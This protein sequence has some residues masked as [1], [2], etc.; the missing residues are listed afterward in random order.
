M[1]QALNDIGNEPLKKSEELSHQESPSNLNEPTQII[2]EEEKK[3]TIPL[4]NEPPQTN[5]QISAQSY[6]NATN[7]QSLKQP[8][9]KNE[10]RSVVLPQ[11]AKEN[12][13]TNNVKMVETKNEEDLKF[14]GEHEEY[15]LLKKQENSR[16]FQEAWENEKKD[17]YNIILWDSENW[18]HLV[19]CKDLYNALAKSIIDRTE[20]ISILCETIIK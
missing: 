4:E 12:F 1:S 9:V 15:A 10:S 17:Y 18:K 19:I 20:S 14:I 5:S 8:E 6:V 13:G 11:R 3:E 7:S 16:K 2:L